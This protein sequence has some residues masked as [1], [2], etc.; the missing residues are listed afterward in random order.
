MK[1]NLTFLLTA[2]LLLTG[3]N[4]WAQSRAEITDVLNRDLT[5]VTSTSYTGWEGKT[6]TE[7]Q[8]QQFWHHHHCIWWNPNQCY[9]YL[10]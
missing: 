10:E 8:R 4:V 9:C 5:G 1:R 3:L 7:K 2:L 6:S